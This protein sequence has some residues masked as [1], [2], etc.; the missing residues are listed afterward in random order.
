ME[1]GE[2]RVAANALPCISEPHPLGRMDKYSSCT[3]QGQVVV[4]VVARR[5]LNQDLLAVQYY[6]LPLTA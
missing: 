1:S 5:C 4:V 6:P 2:R 3:P